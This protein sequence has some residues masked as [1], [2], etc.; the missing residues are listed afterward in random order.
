[1]FERVTLIGRLG[2]EPEMRYTASGIPVCNFSFATTRTINK[3]VKEE[4][5]KGWKEG[6]KGKTW[7]LSVWWR[8]TFW[9]GQAETVNQYCSKGNQLYI[10]GEIG[11]T[12]EGGSQ[13]PNVWEGKDGISRASYELTGRMF[14]FMG[15]N[16]GGGGYTPSDEDAPPLS[17]GEEVKLPF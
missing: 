1:M 3:Q 15:S 10:E 11:G 14:K 7:E 2:S 4:C 9:R 6:Y 8:V 12:A 13:N 16:N 17:G 5:P